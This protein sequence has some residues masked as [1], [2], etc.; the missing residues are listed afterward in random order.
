MIAG[1]AVCLTLLEVAIL[2]RAARGATALLVPVVAINTL[3]TLGYLFW[4]NVAADGLVSAQL[5]ASPEQ[6]HAALAASLWFTVAL[7]VGGVVI[8]P[9]SVLLAGGE[10]VS[11]PAGALVLTAYLI[12]ALQLYGVRSDVLRAPEYLDFSGPRW[13]VTISGAF[14]PMALLALC[15]AVSQPG[16]HRLF[17]VIGLAAWVLVLFGASSRSIALVPGMLVMGY[18]LSRGVTS[19]RGFAVRVAVA[20]VTTEVLAEMALALRSNPGGVGILPLGERLWSDPSI[21]LAPNQVLGNVLFSTPL[22]GAVADIA[23]PRAAFWTAINPLP[24][25]MTD[26][27]AIG[28]FLRINVNTPFSGLGELA[29]QGVGVLVIYGLAAGLALSWTTRIADALPGVWRTVG[30]FSVLALVTLFS[31]EMLQYNL[32]AGTRLLWYALAWMLFLRVVAGFATAGGASEPRSP[33]PGPLVR[34][35]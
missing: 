13:A 27:P 2:Y 16:R 26:W 15:F 20:I 6:L 10:G 3:M 4:D 17:A 1:L 22:T 7:T 24:G 14:V 8:A 34:R 21:V 28:P 11:L 32:R 31:L 18:A 29:A 33:A 25:A 5:A 35:T 9:R 19:R 23:I 12:L 30:V